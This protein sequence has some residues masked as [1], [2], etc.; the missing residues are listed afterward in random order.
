MIS[1]LVLLSVVSER[2]LGKHGSKRVN[3]YT[4]KILIRIII[5][6]DRFYIALY[7]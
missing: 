1:N 4:Y 2:R 3:V 5:I 7:T 6:T